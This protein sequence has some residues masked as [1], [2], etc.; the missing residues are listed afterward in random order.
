MTN[1]LIG[2]LI[3]FTA[4]V[5]TTYAG[6]LKEK[7][8]IIYANS[9]EKILCVISNIVLGGITGAITNAIAFV[10]NIL[11]YKDKFR[12]KQK[13][14]IILSISILSLIF[15]NL[16]LIGILPV[17]GTAI[18]TLFMDTK[19]IIKFKILSISTTALWLIYN[20]CIMSYTAGVIEIFQI[21][22]NTIAIFRITNDR[23]V[24]KQIDNLR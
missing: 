21:T 11:C 14:L 8:E 18:Y 12:L 13:I 10:R 3:A 6:I 7:D 15:N 20:F 2:N 23:K 16:G 9:V 5:L 4:S 24:F 19:D 1:I 22:T 17:I